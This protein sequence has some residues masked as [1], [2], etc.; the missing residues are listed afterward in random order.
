MT[1]GDTGDRPDFWQRNINQMPGR[2]KLPGI[3]R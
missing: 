1:L 2:F 3:P